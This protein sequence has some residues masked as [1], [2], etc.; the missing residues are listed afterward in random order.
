M[1]SLALSYHWT[2]RYTTEEISKHISN[3]MQSVDKIPHR[4]LLIIGANINAAI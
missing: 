1:T 4:N 2:T 3:T